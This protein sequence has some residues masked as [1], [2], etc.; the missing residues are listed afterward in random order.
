M[1]VLTHDMGIENNEDGDSRLRSEGMK[2]LKAEALHILDEINT[3]YKVKPLAKAVEDPRFER[4]QLRLRESEW[5][6]VVDEFWVVDGVPYG[7]ARLVRKDSADCVSI[8]GKD[9]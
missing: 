3:I 7:K 6:T 5:R 9:A 4:L 8:Y 1:L 2:I